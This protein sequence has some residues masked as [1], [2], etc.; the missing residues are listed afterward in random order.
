[1][2]TITAETGVGLRPAGTQLQFV[3]LLICSVY[4]K[5]TNSDDIRKLSEQYTTMQHLTAN[6]IAKTVSGCCVTH[7][8]K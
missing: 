8:K 6:D 5:A 2:S 4:G 3:L 1:M 7:T